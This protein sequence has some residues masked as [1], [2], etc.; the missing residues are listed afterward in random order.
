MP[1]LGGVAN[2]VTSLKDAGPIGHWYGFLLE[3]FYQFAHGDDTPGKVAEEPMVKEFCQQF[4]LNLT[5]EHPR[6]AAGKS[7]QEKV[8]RLITGKNLDPDALVLIHTGPSW[9]V[10]EYCRRTWVQLVNQL[11]DAGWQSIAQMGGSYQQFNNVAAKAAKESLPGTISLI[12][13]FSVEECVAAIAQAKLFIGIDSGLLHI[14]AAT[15]TQAV[16]IFGSTS[17]QFLYGEMFRRDFVVTEVACAG[18]FHRQPRDPLVRQ[19]PA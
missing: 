10:K 13:A 19:L 12:N 4:G 9:T 14:A 15:R 7:A 18:C 2:Q 17:P 5:E 11:R 6:L 16:G 8:R 3:G 1:R